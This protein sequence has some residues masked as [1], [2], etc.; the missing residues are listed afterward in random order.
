MNIKATI[1]GSFANFLLGSDTFDRIKGV[2]LRQEEKDIPGAEKRVAAFDEI[3]LIGMGVA[4][5]AVNLAIEL[6]VTYLRTLAGNSS[7]NA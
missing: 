6:A 3:K 1:I 5:W 4:T 7:K 2:V